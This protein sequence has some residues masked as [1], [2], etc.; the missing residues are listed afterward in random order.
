MSKKKK[1]IKE[2]EV[3]TSLTFEQRV[4][5]NLKMQENLLEQPTNENTASFDQQEL[6]GSRAFMQ[7]MQTAKL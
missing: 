2:Q 6:F 5:N 4:A 1:T 7:K 3:D